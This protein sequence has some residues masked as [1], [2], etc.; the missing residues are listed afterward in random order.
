MEIDNFNIVRTFEDLMSPERYALVT[1]QAAPEMYGLDPM[2]YTDIP[3]YWIGVSTSRTFRRC[4]RKWG[5]QSSY[6]FGLDKQGTTENINFWFGSAIHF[7]MEDYFGWNKFGDPRRAFKAYYE[8]FEAVDRPNEAEEHYELGMKMLEYFL[9]WYPRHNQGLV[10]DHLETAWFIQDENSGCWTLVP[11]HTEGADPGV[12]I[13]IELDLGIRLIVDADDGKIYARDIPD[14]LDP[15]ARIFES[16][17]SADLTHIPLQVSDTIY[18]IKLG[19]E[20]KSCKVVPIRFHGTIDRVC[21]DSFGRL[22]LLDYKTA[23]GADTNK[24]DTDDQV[25]RY[26]W[27][28]EQ[29]LGMPIE[30]FVYLQLTKDVP[31]APRKL[32]KGGISSDVSQRTTRALYKQALVDL[33]GSV[34]AAPAANIK[35]LNA[36]AE[37]EFPE[38]DPFIRWDFV[39][40]T[41][42]EKVATYYNIL[43]EVMAMT[44]PNKPLFSSPTRDCI[45]DCPF[46]GACLALDK[47]AWEEFQLALEE[48]A[49]RQIERGADVPGWGCRVKWPEVPL[50][51]TVTPE[52]LEL[53]TTELNVILPD[54]YLQPKE[55]EEE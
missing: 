44:D 13:G 4:L 31:K 3:R 11:P 5:F 34:E 6:R 9:D 50:A 52:E 7:A 28:A 36:L 17:V 45:W 24:L 12:E 49:P 2:K 8:A 16:F 48:Y 26:M 20:E 19:S 1:M 14:P 46:R 23:K 10:G 25:S 42:H 40:R 22:Y 43:A 41:T 21:V 15:E 18:T 30:G 33:Y 29:Y 27:A 37:K 54:K 51:A 35:C 53:D 32:Q 39:L 38:G 55:I 47:G